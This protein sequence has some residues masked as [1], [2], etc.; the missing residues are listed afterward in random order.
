[1]SDR[2]ILKQPNNVPGSG[3][4]TPN[5]TTTKRRVS[6]SRQR[7]V[8]HF[9]RTE[10]N[11]QCDTVLEEM[12]QTSSSGSNTHVMPSTPCTPDSGSGLINS[13]MAVFDV[14][15]SADGFDFGN[16]KAMETMTCLDNTAAVFGS[17]EK[18][19]PE[20]DNIT[21]FE[22]TNFSTP[23]FEEITSSDGSDDMDISIARTPTRVVRNM[24]LDASAMDIST[25]PSVVQKRKSNS[26][27]MD[28]SM[29]PVSMMRKKMLKGQESFENKENTS[30]DNGELV[31]PISCRL[32]NSLLYADSPVETTPKL[33]ETGKSSRNVT[34]YRRRT[35]NTIKNTSYSI[36]VISTS[37]AEDALD[38]S[39][40]E[41][42]NVPGKDSDQSFLMLPS[43]GR[44]NNLDFLSES[45]FTANDI[46]SSK[47]AVFKDVTISSTGNSFTSK[48]ID[49]SYNED[50][51]CFFLNKSDNLN[52]E[53]DE[54][55]TSCKDIR[56][57][58]MCGGRSLMNK[59]VED[60]SIAAKSIQVTPLITR[61]R[62]TVN[63]NKDDS[64]DIADA[65]KKYAMLEEIS[66]ND[67]LGRETSPNEELFNE[68]YDV[69]GSEITSKGLADDSLNTSKYKDDTIGTPS[70]I[71][72]NEP[73]EDN[74]E[75]NDM[76]LG[77]L[78][79]PADV[80]M[81][82][83]CGD[84]INEDQLAD[85]V[86][87]INPLVKGII[88]NKN[89][90]S[91]GDKCYQ[92]YLAMGFLQSILYKES[93]II[94][95]L[96]PYVVGFDVN[97]HLEEFMIKDESSVD[98]EELFK[99]IVELE[100]AGDIGFIVTQI[101]RINMDKYTKKLERLKIIFNMIFEMY[102]ILVDYHDVRRENALK[103]INNKIDENRKLL[104]VMKTMD[105]EI[106][107]NLLDVNSSLKNIL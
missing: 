12:D 83:V 30:L 62:P 53:R 40:L 37:I 32:S 56:E 54:S 47:L 17:S 65:V 94:P 18:T 90:E 4:V 68:T 58:S 96:A 3:M 7:I 82:S 69:S 5:N 85:D 103:F 98:L 84:S 8:Q 48:T 55:V 76:I 2:S 79:N 99:M 72:V 13:T 45:I 87:Y 21:N 1:M 26:T 27:S 71:K 14:T 61:E 88:Y 20:H 23:R 16:S 44:N 95:D 39:N 35:I 19:T 75:N 77:D 59:V 57:E 81:K 33:N 97:K 60:V 78:Y 92:F 80:T 107:R 36:D 101:R 25:T 106:K 100:H 9:D 22:P 34:P 74:A 70:N 38:R 51:S 63:L 46:S 6:F 43:P 24:T 50:S 42:E 64:I 31:T 89:Y 10:V 41:I 93:S 15:L 52:K 49:T 29:T 73:L 86:N 104:D 91:C 66:P 11:F 28:V 105:E 67:I 102:L